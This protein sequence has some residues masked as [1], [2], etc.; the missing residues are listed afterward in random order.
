MKS[1]WSWNHSCATYTVRHG[2]AQRCHCHYGKIVAM[3]ECCMWSSL[4]L[5]WV[6]YDSTFNVD[7]GTQ[8]FPAEHTHIIRLPTM[9][10]FP[11]VHSGDIAYSDWLVTY[12]QPLNLF[13]RKQDSL[14]QVISFHWYKVQLWAMPVYDTFIDWHWL[15]CIL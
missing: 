15:T 5:R 13:R 6:V 1:S 14:N 8:C 10:C 11:R 4:V 3:K 12:T 2:P 7:D 9:V